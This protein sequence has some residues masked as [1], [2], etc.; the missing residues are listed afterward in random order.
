MLWLY[1]LQDVFKVLFT[2]VKAIKTNAHKAIE[3]ESTS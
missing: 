2:L 3:K 1:I